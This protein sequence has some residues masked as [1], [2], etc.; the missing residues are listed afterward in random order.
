MTID[1]VP[2]KIPAL[3]RVSDAI[4]LCP[5]LSDSDFRVY[6]I[7]RALRGKNSTTH[8]TMNE[9]CS[10]VPSPSGDDTS[11]SK[12]RRALRYL[13]GAGVISKP[14]GSNVTTSS[15]TR[16]HDQVMRI[17]VRD[18]PLAGSEVSVWEEVRKLRRDRGGK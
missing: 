14:D 18:L 2:R 3:T 16:S 7:L 10:L 6:C 8:I 4:T 12:I 17:V 11:V 9:L 15:R 1:P 13:S 5:Y